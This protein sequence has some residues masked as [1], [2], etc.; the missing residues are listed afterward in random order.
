M[1]NEV[2]QVKFITAM[3]FVKKGKFVAIGTYSGRCFFYTTD[4][5]NSEKKRYNKIYKYI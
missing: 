5:S 3:T 1:W 2:E 4:V